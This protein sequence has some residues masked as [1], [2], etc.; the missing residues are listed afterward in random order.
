M[1]RTDVM[2]LSGGTRCAGWLYRPANTD[3]DVPCVVMAHGFALTRHDNLN[4]YAEALARAGAAVL[5][6]D[7]RYLGDSEGEPRQRVRISEQFDDC[8]AAIA[9]ARTLDGID[10]DR[11]VVWGYSLSGGNAVE[12][13]AAD[14]GVAGVILL[15]PLL[16]AKERLVHGIRTQP[17]N[18]VWLVGRA[19][20]DA[21][22][23]VS[24]EPG[25]RGAMT[26]PGELDGFRSAVAPGWRNEVRAGLLFAMLTYRPLV[27]AGKL[28]C[29]VLIQAGT[30]D[31]SVSARAVDQFAQRA[32]YAALKRYDVD[33]FQPFYGNH[34][35]QIIADQADW[36]RAS[37]PASSSDRPER[38][39]HARG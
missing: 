34:P 27:H 26:F 1:D 16:D 3:G 37:I 21:I 28:K 6:Y 11:I 22:I 36:L 19:I 10:P 14:E 18:S 20:R 23:P 39:N 33:H 2:F 32:P 35:A 5:V 25:G 31:I 24:D 15:C 29:P 7:H 30:R 4:L 17:G 12:A 13:A 9:F 8:L 38:R